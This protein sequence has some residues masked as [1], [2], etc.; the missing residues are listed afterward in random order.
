M[1]YILP[2]QTVDVDND[3]AGCIRGAPCVHLYDNAD[4]I[5]RTA[6]CKVVTS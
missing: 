6:L 2:M 4:T 3:C 1:N 5:P